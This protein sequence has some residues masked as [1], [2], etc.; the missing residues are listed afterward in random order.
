MSLHISKSLKTRKPRH[1][2]G[3]GRC[4][5]SHNV[6]DRVSRFLYN[7]RPAVTSSQF[8]KI[9]GGL[10]S[11][12]FFN[13]MQPAGG[14]LDDWALAECVQHLQ[15]EEKFT[16]VNSE[17]AL[18]ADIHPNKGRRRVIRLGTDLQNVRWS[19]ST[20]AVPLK[21]PRNEFQVIDW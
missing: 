17:D 15:D 11:L 20:V 13:S 3:H 7:A 18:R 21:P 10:S 4:T 9:T 8:D 6:L 16:P 1:I 5:V 14:E 19:L 12:R 2:R